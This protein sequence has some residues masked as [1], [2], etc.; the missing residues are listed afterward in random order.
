MPVRAKKLLTTVSDVTVEGLALR[1][2]VS[3]LKVS[4]NVNTI[5]AVAF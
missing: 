5:A 3:D 2:P 1:V 4:E